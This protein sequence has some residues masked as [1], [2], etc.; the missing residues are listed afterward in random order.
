M[1]LADVFVSGWLLGFCVGVLACVLMLARA[2]KQVA[3]RPAVERRSALPAIRIHRRVD[4]R[5]VRAGV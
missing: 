3:A 1:S 5:R 4:E 2:Q